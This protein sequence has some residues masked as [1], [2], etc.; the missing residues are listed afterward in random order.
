MWWYDW[1]IDDGS[2]EDGSAFGLT[3]CSTTLLMIQ[4]CCCGGILD[5]LSLT[6]QGLID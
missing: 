4:Y 3:W 6:L 2:G 1:D 5:S